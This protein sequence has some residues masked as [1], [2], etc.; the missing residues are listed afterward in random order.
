M[1]FVSKV[2]RMVTLKSIFFSVLFSAGFAQAVTIPEVVARLGVI[3]KKIAN[4]CEDESCV[5]DPHLFESL[6]NALDTVEKEHQVPD[7]LW[8]ACASVNSLLDV[9]STQELFMSL[10]PYFDR[11]Q[12]NL[13]KVLSA[14]VTTLPRRD[15]PYQSQPVEVALFDHRRLLADL[16]DAG[17]GFDSSSGSG[18]PCSSDDDE[19]DKAGLHG[20]SS[21]RRAPSA[22]SPVSSMSVSSVLSPRSV[23]EPFDTELFSESLPWLGEQ[24]LSLVP[25]FLSVDECFK[26]SAVSDLLQ[27]HSLAVLDEKP[28]TCPSTTLID[29]LKEIDAQLKESVVLVNTI[30]CEIAEISDHSD[31]HEALV[32]VE[33]FV[34]GR[35]AQIE[36]WLQSVSCLV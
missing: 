35:S 33:S 20:S 6:Q 16:D 15:T 12:T 9:L 36:A 14:Q 21:A 31:Q 24:I 29:S 17:E 11:L 13:K 22:Y 7:D 3:A 2:L 8:K 10:W 5:F 34:S 30:A 27:G 1:F 26:I 25:V 32:Q 28:T 18:S 4:I 23:L 19:Y